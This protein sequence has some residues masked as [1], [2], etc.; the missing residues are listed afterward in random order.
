MQHQQA[1]HLHDF[2]EE[3]IGTVMPVDQ[4][5]FNKVFYHI[6]MAWSDYI[7]VHEDPDIEEFCH[8]WNNEYDNFQIVP[9]SIYFYQP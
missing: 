7:S 3:I 2:E 5:Q 4:R 6:K 9:L 8:I 1:I